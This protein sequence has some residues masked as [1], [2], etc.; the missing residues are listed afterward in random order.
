[1]K[2]A[3]KILRLLWFL[4][5]SAALAESIYDYLNGKEV[6][7]RSLFMMVFFFLMAYLNHRKV[8]MQAEA[9]DEGKAVKE[10]HE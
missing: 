10:N 6:E 5:G 7:K 1:M 9:T 8:K 4:I 2:K 3:P